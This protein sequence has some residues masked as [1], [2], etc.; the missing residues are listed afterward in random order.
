MHPA[1][2]P[3]YSWG[4]PTGY[5]PHHGYYPPPA[6]YY[7]PGVGDA[8]STGGDRAAS[9]PAGMF[10]AGGSPPL[11]PGFISV[12]L[13][14]HHHGSSPVYGPSPGSSPPGH[15][16]YLPP[17]HGGGGGGGEYMSNSHPDAISQRFASMSLMSNAQGT[18]SGG[19]PTGSSTSGRGDS[20][21][22]ARIARSHRAGGAYNPS[23]F[24]FNVEEAESGL[25]GA[26]TTVMVRNIP[27][28]YTQQTMIAMLEDAGLRGTFD[29][30]YLPIDFRN[31]CGLGYAFVNFLS[32]AAAAKAYRHFHGRRWDE[33]NSK[34]VCEITYARVQ[35]R[36]SLVQHF[37]TAKFP[38]EEAEYQ[39][40]VYEASKTGGADAPE[41]GSENTVMAHSPLP[42]HAYLAAHA[43]K[44]RTSD[45]E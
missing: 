36:D 15:Y 6:G 8:L 11:A 5:A 7:P 27:N 1:L 21:A 22:S 2:M 19:S 35:G 38:S 43:S 9:P 16:M 28:K 40:L 4:M 17:H 26:R 23:D 34:K 29:F 30:F 32:S 24:Q 10:P 13:H 14:Q 42:I 12:P 39:P 33:F 41:D 37:K 45:L 44:A 18:V 20:R 3:A 31:R 25:Q